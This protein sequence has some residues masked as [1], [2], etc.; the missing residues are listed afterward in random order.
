MES[1]NVREMIINYGHR[2][3]SV[4]GFSGPKGV[5]DFVRGILPNNSQEH[6]VVIPLDSSN[7]PLSWHIASSGL[8]DACNVH[9]RETFRPA[10]AAGATKIIV[11]HNHPTDEVSPS[12]AD[13]EITS[14]LK[15][16]GE[17]LGIAL[18]DHLIVTRE[19]HYSFED[20]G[21]LIG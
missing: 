18:L 4:E 13:K 2:K 6:F 3:M 14:R 9:P 16:A 1:T 17:L 8:V 12:S 19:S 21:T 10:I 11:A 15:K 7:K 20:S 5:A